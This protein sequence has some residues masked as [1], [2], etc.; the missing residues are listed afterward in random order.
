MEMI[1]YQTWEEQLRFWEDKRNILKTETEY[2]TLKLAMLKKEDIRDK[3]KV[4]EW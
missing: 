3:N 2:W 1:E 4:S